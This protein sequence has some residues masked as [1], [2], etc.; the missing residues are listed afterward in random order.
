[1]Y[2]ATNVSGEILPPSSRLSFY[3]VLLPIC[4]ATRRHVPESFTLSLHRRE[5][6]TRHVM[7]SVLERD[8]LEHPEAR[9]IL[10]T[11]VL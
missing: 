3:A 8:A 4:Q 9:R 6:L 7:G 2:F 10:L 11:L 1:M 5:E